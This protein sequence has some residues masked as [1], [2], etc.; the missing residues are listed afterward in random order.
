MPRRSPNRGW[1]FGT[2]WREKATGFET[3]KIEALEHE[4]LTLTARVKKLR[5]IRHK[6]VDKIYLRRN[7]PERYQRKPWPNTSSPS[8]STPQT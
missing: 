6:L 1:V 7:Y 2:S 3:K 5:A 8:R 4:I